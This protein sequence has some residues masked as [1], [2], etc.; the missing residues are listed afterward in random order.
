MKKTMIAALA[1]VPV[2]LLTS[3]S[4]TTGYYDTGYSNTYTYTTTPNYYSDYNNVGV[5]LLGAGLLGYGLGSSYYGGGYYNRGWHGGGWRNASWRHGGGWHRG[6]G[7]H[8]GFRGGR[9]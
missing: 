7:F 6:G 2:M 9:R 1:F 5:G 3:C 4:T 8:R